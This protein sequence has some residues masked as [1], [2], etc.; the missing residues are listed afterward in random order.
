MQKKIAESSAAYPLGHGYQTNLMRVSSGP[1]LGRLVALM[2]V[3]GVLKLSWSD[4]PATTWS[5]P[6]TV[7]A[8][9]GNESFD[10][11]MDEQDNILLI[12]CDSPTE[13]LTFM[14]LTYSSGQWTAGTPVPVFNVSPGF[15][16]SLAVDPE[17]TYWVSFS[18]FISPARRITVK[19]SVDGGATWGTGPDDS[20][21]E[22]KGTILFGWS[23]TVVDSHSVHVI[24]HD[25]DNAMSIRSRALSG[26]DWSEPF[27]IAIGSGFG[28]HFHAAVASNGRLG[29]V[30]NNGGLCYREFNGSDW[31]SPVTIDEDPAYSPQLG[32]EENTPVVSY[33]SLFAESQFIARC[34]NRRTGSFSTP[35]VLDKRSKPFDSV[36]LYE[37][38]SDTYEIA[39]AVAESKT[40]SDLFHSVSGRLLKNGSDALY[41]G[42]EDRFRLCRFLLS[43]PGAGGALE[44]SYWDGATWQTF[45]PAN[46]TLDL[47]SATSDVLFWAD[48]YSVPVDWQKVAVDGDSRFWVRIEVTSA[49]ATGPIGSQATSVP[50]LSWLI[51][52]R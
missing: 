26:G 5:A 3:D 29:V 11:R 13:Y 2:N 38:V 4:S 9:I 7:V 41:L 33:L 37:A 52:R 49:F 8:D 10:C 19:S 46:G 6:Q 42:M 34:S 17:G 21:D 44:F 15:D 28:R 31:Q 43:A 36:I 45:T 24:F 32:F 20:G 27:N 47:S 16:P 30:F 22:I 1:Y 48:Y 35:V 12:Y 14:K 25:Q 18:R 39:T 40:T 51:L 23:Q 50:P